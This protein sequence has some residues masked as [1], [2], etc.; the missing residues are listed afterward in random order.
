MIRQMPALVALVCLG[1]LVVGGP[2]QAAAPLGP[3]PLLVSYP[4][5]VV[6]NAKVVTADDRFTIHQALAIRDGK[7]LAL[8]TTDHI[9]AL[10]GPGTRVVDAAC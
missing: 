2:A 10:V 5:L 7:I 8:G 9:R 1:L 4:K 6:V 3:P